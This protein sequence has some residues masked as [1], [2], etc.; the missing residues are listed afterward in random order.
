MYQAKHILIVDGNHNSNY[1]RI[2]GSH[3]QANNF[4]VHYALDT[5]TAQAK[6]KQLPIHAALVNV[7]LIN[8]RDMNDWSG[9]DLAEHLRP[10]TRVV[11]MAQNPTFEMTRKALVPRINAPAPACDFVA[12]SE[13]TQAMLAALHKAVTLSQTAAKTHVGGSRQTAAL[14]RPKDEQWHPRSTQRFAL[15]HHTRTAKVDGETV[16]L[17]ERE[18]RLMRFFLDNAE[19]VITREDIVRQV[20]KEIYDPYADCNRV[21]NIISRLRRRVEPLP[22]EPQFIITR[23]GSGWMFYPDGDA[24]QMS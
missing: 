4:V 24:P 5:Y 7:R 10:Y 21:N 19:S 11:M 1:A 15:D 8:E 22:D 3:L 2:L 13:G 23:W 9:I 12:K 18:Y 6:V 14:G 16:T 17:T 20:L